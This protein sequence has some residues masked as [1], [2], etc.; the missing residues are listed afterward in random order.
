MEVVIH[1]IT[2]ITVQEL[3]ITVMIKTLHSPTILYP[4]MQMMIPTTTQGYFSLKPVLQIRMYALGV[5]TYPPPF[6]VLNMQFVPVRD[7]MAMSHS[8]ISR[9]IQMDPVVLRKLPV[10]WMPTAQM[11]RRAVV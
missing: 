7:A 11:A 9:L 10:T 5:I 3:V 6:K 2:A 4:S 8:I 1:S